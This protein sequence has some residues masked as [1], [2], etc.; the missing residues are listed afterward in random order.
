MRHKTL[1]IRLL[2]YYFFF[3]LQK[4]EKGKTE[5]KSTLEQSE[6]S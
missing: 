3:I 2:F 6:A 4:L 1:L 5:I